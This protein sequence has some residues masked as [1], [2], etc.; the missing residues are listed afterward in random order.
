MREGG[1]EEGTDHCFPDLGGGREGG[2]K[3]CSLKKICIR[4]HVQRGREGGR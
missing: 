1:R 4:T 3:G 2:R